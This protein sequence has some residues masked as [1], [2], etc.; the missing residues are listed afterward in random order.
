M[1]NMKVQNLLEDRNN[2]LVVA[3]DACAAMVMA[4]TDVGDIEA[5]VILSA[6]VK[7]QECLI[8]A[9]QTLAE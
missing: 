4:L 7:A 5:F 3:K 6:N 2:N 8:E 1:S 9:F